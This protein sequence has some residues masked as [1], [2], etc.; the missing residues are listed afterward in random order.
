MGNRC[1]RVIKNRVII[2]TAT[3]SL[4][5]VLKIKIKK[6]MLLKKEIA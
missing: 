2:Y 4:K 3:K 6:A 1:Q 5:M